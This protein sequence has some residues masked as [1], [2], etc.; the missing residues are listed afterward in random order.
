M[1]PI[2]IFFTN[3]NNSGLHK[4][5]SSVQNTHLIMTKF[6]QNMYFES[7]YMH[8]ILLRNILK[9]IICTKVFKKIIR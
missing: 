5:S 7:K 4:L 8:E 1:S 2:N 3:N 9:V 6:A